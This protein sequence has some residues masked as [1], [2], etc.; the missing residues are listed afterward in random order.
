[1][2]KRDVV[3]KLEKN[4]EGERISRKLENVLDDNFL[5][6]QKIND[7]DFTPNVGTSV[8]QVGKRKFAR[9]TI[10]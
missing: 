10:S 3:D 7:K 5:A 9:V 4:M 2:R 6:I 1:M 8:Y